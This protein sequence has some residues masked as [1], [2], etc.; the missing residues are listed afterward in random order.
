MLCDSIKS[1]IF[2]GFYFVSIWSLKIQIYQLLCFVFIPVT[3]IKPYQIEI[4]LP[5][6]LN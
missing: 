2:T 5:G 6:T 4:L 3:G 1:Q